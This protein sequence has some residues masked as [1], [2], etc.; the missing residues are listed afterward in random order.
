MSFDLAEY[1]EENLDCRRQVSK[2]EEIQVDC[3]NPECDDNWRHHKKMA[4]NTEKQVAFCFKCGKVYRNAVEIVAEIEKI[5]RFAALKIVKSGIKRTYGPNRLETALFGKSE[6]VEPATAAVERPAI[7]LPGC[8]PIEPGMEAYDYL[9]GRGFNESVIE[10]FGLRFQPAGNYRRRILIPVIADGKL[11][12]FQGRAIDSGVLPKYLFPR[13]GASHFQSVLYNWDQA[14]HYPVL[15]LVEGVTDAW[16]LWLKGFRN[17]CATFGKSLKTEQRKLIL[18]NP[19]TKKVVLF[20]DGEAMDKI[21]KTA[22][23]LVGLIDVFAVELP[24]DMEPDTCPDPGHY[25]ATAKQVKGMTP[26]ER[27]LRG[28]RLG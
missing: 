1:I 17:V 19:V 3:I 25:I 16:R 22:G 10:Q 23:E 24:A 4:V 5:S 27:K 6:E 20:W 28:A 14:R 18:E 11:V 13:E 2:P 21:Y 7:K 15:I 9:I 26:L 12:T 8:I